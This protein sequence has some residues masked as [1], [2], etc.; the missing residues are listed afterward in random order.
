M[1][2]KIEIWHPEPFANGTYS[3]FNGIE[4]EM[5]WVTR[6]TPKKHYVDDILFEYFGDPK[7]FRAKGCTVKAKSR[8]Q[9]FSI[10]D[11]DT[12]FCNMWNVLKEVEGTNIKIDT[13]E[14][15]YKPDDPEVTCKTY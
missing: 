3:L 15:K 14:C 8:S 10:Y 4:D 9:T 7:D 1:K 11:Y 12:N 6:T 5:L 2:D 13:S